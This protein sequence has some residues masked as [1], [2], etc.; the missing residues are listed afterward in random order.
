MCIYIY[1]HIYIYIYRYIHRHTHGRGRVSR[2]HTA[3][4]KGISYPLTVPPVPLQD[5]RAV[6]PRCVDVDPGNCFDSMVD[7]GRGT[8]R[9]ED[10]QGTPTQSHM[11]PSILENTK[12]TQVRRPHES[13][14]TAQRFSKRYLFEVRL[15]SEKNRNI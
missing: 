7:S 2:D 11:S 12:M 13:P 9:A 6:S 10:A 4:M 8:T 5:L 15:A 3:D 1:I 14:A